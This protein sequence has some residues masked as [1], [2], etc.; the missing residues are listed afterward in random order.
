MN[1]GDSELESFSGSVRLFPLPNLVMFPHVD[2]LLHIFEQRYRQMTADALGDDRLI[3]TALLVDGSQAMAKG[4]PSIHSG[5]CI[6]RIIAE[7][8]LD[9][10]RFLLMLRGLRRAR[11]LTETASEVPY[12]T[13]QVQLIPDLVTLPPVELDDLRQRLAN[14]IL[15]RLSDPDSIEQLTE[16]F[17]DERPLGDVCDFLGYKLP[18]G[19]A[20]KQKLLEEA[21]VSV[22]AR[23]LLDELGTQ[24]PSP[25]PET[26]RFPPDFS[27]N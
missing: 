17:H 12:R 20:C 26:R 24:L 22:R 8:E 11:I 13:A 4:L 16:L 5:V 21:D 27:L 15:P 7:K 1:D 25:T 3:A 19:L 14:Q 23:I 10:G 9:D 18:L 2:Q 6:G